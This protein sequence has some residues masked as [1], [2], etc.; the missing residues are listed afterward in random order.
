MRKK[1]SEIIKLTALLTAGITASFAFSGCLNPISIDSCGYVVTVGA[2]I[3]K[4][5]PYEVILELQR[6]RSNV[7]NESE[8]GAIILSEEGN[9]IFEVIK[10]LSE[11]IPFQLNFT[12]THLFVFSEAL[13]RAGLIKD[14]LEMSFDTLKIR[15]SALMLITHCSVRDYIGGL[16]SN[17]NANLSKLQDDLMNDVNHSGH[18]AIINLNRFYESCREKRFDP[19][20]PMGFYNDRILTD[21]KQKDTTLKGEN[22]LEEGTSGVRLGGMK[23]L[24]YGAALFDGAVMTGTLDA[25]DTQFMNLGRGTFK[26]G[27]ISYLCDDGTV[28]TFTLEIDKRKVNIE[29]EKDGNIRAETDLKLN[30]TVQQ[31]AGLIIGN[32]WESGM[33][34]TLEK[35][36][37]NELKRVFLKCRNCN[38]DAMGFGR[39]VSKKFRKTSEWEAFDWKQAYKNTDADFN[40]ELKLDD[41]YLAFLR[42]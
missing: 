25:D 30:L 42:H 26:N 18:A 17:N 19:A 27:S 16:N 32:N 12:R 15:E 41:R 20:I 11:G 28:L 4:N 8:G 37:E 1:N 3:G 9:N 10:K 22:P 13:A 31:D 38:C 6:E 34:E 24:T 33:K 29:M 39:D 35:F 40:V 36:I 14:F 21:V 23:S 7:S 2:D 5:A